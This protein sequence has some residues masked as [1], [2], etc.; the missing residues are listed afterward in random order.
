MKIYWIDTSCHNFGHLHWIKQFS[1]CSYT[2]CES[3]GLVRSHFLR[4]NIQIIFLFICRLYHNL[5]PWLSIMVTKLQPVKSQV[6]HRFCLCTRPYWTGNEAV[7]MGLRCK[8]FTYSWR[9]FHWNIVSHVHCL[10]NVFWLYQCD[11]LDW[12]LIWSQGP[13][14]EMMTRQ[15]EYLK[16][17]PWVTH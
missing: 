3:F 8:W 5:P 10:H 2:H 12:V 16:W 6:F 7:E 9:R 1:R 17:V 4:Y 15:Q 11:M 13:T 14:V